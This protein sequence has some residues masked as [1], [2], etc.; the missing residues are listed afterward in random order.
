MSVCLRW[1]SLLLQIPSIWDVL[2]ISF[3]EGAASLEHAH[4]FLRR[5]GTCSL[6]ITLLWDDY[7]LIPQAV[8]DEDDL[9]VE[10]PASREEI[11][12]GVHLG[13]VIYE[14]YA[15]VYRWRE[16]T[17]RATSV[18]QMYHALGLMSRPSIHTAH[19]LEKLHLQLVHNKNHTTH[20]RNEPSLSPAQHLP[21]MIS[22]FL[23]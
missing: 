11:M 22:C 18:A 3:H 17:L 23:V 14:L 13:F 6:Y 12:T 16:F 5:S 7:N 2:H 15:Q 19:I 1:K 4:T 9:N 21:S 8:P 10:E 20:H